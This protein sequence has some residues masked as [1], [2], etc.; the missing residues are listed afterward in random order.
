MVAVD[1]HRAS[2]LP[3]A[4]DGSLVQVLLGSSKHPQRLE[5]GALAELTVRQLVS[6][7]CG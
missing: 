7:R 1:C 3:A 2:G 6:R 4:A 5:F